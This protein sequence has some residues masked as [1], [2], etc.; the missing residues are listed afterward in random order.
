MGKNRESAEISATAITSPPN[1]QQTARRILNILR[2][3]V[4]HSLRANLAN[5][6]VVS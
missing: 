3:C 6:L 1:C 2:F 4:R 5:S